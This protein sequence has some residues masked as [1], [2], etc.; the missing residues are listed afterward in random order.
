VWPWPWPWNWMSYTCA[1]RSQIVFLHLTLKSKVMTLNKKVTHIFVIYPLCLCNFCLNI[2]LSKYVQGRR[3]TTM[4][5]F[6]II[7]WN[8]SAFL[9]FQAEGAFFIFSFFQFVKKVKVISKFWFHFW[10]LLWNA[11]KMVLCLL[12]L[13]SMT[14][15]VL[16][17]FLIIA[18]E[19]Y[20]FL[21]LFLDVFRRYLQ[22]GKSE[23]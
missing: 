7:T 23:K 11:H 8:R 12:E 10:I 21:G 20:W 13:V 5:D 16:D 18:N 1:T 14:N 15:V 17:A 4:Y 19:F 22:N 9:N 6:I 3:Y 2:C